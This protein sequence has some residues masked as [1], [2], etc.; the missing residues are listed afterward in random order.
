MCAVVLGGLTAAPAHSKT[1]KQPKTFRESGSIVTWGTVTHMDF[2]VECPNIPLT[3]GLDSYVVEIPPELW[4]VPAIV[5]LE[6][7]QVGAGGTGGN[8]AFYSTSCEQGELTVPTPT[9][10]PYGTRFIVVEPD[11]FNAN[12]TFDLTI[13]PRRRIVGVPPPPPAEEGPDTGKPFVA[14][15]ATAVGGTATTLSFMATCP[16]I[17]P[18]QG[19]DAHIVELPPSLWTKPS[20]ITV[21]MKATGLSPSAYVTTLD[22]NCALAHNYERAPIDTQG[23]TRFVVVSSNIGSV[24]ATFRLEV[25]PYR[26]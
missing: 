2:I 9:T 3:Q 5:E 8:L 22:P 14:E 13:K 18:L 10:L 19:V 12:I 15:G 20:R 23:P 16:E 7:S 24:Q 11:P 25:A 26:P 21:D 4:N 1:Q 6:M 17:T